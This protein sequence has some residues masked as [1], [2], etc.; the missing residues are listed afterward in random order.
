MCT[1][2]HPQC[3]RPLGGY[4]GAVYVANLTLARCLTKHQRGKQ[5]FCGH[6]Q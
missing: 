4:S 2:G 1:I 6:C 5:W 3:Y